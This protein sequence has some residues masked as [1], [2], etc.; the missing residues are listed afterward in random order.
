MMV[1]D[2]PA[3]G[4]LPI[5]LASGT[6]AAERR[7]IVRLAEQAEL[8]HVARSRRDPVGSSSARPRGPI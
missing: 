4:Y 8:D 7:R 2:R 6:N 5:R 3:V 1:A